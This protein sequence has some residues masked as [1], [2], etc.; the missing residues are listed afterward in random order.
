M[1]ISSACLR[2]TA[3]KNG[4]RSSSTIISYPF[5]VKPKSYI[6]SWPRDCVIRINDAANEIIKR[7]AAQLTSK[8]LT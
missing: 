4:G 1:T 8:W 5:I 3:F 2:P 7:G 6:N